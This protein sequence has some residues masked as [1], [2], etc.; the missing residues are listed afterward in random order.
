MRLIVRVAL[1][2]S[3]GGFTQLGTQAG[4]AFAETLGCKGPK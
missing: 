3:D 4:E 1:L 2:A